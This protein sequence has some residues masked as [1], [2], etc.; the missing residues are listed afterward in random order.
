MYSEATMPTLSHFFCKWWIILINENYKSVI[1]LNY[2]TLNHSVTNSVFKKMSFLHLKNIVCFCCDVSRCA[3][4]RKFTLQPQI[5][6]SK[7]QSAI[8]KNG[9]IFAIEYL[10]PLSCQTLHFTCLV[11]LKKE[12]WRN[13]TLPSI[14]W[15]NIFTH[16]NLSVC[17]KR[18]VIMQEEKKKKA[19][20]TH[21]TDM[22]WTW[23]LIQ[24]G[25]DLGRITGNL[26]AGINC[27]N[28]ISTMLSTKRR[29]F[30]IVHF[31][32]LLS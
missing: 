21:V 13:G 28:D 27:L 1:E 24:L 23:P 2:W 14:F 16:L 32:F 6:P 25:S 29:P 7:T 8:F 31:S 19:A 10:K 12:S 26:L 3:F 9:S 15:K 11:Q 22:Y 20:L 30:G 5:I 4:E 17:I 18:E